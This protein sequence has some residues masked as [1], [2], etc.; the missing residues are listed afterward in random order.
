MLSVIAS[1]VFL[2]NMNA[3]ALV[4]RIRSHGPSSGIRPP[5]STVQLGLS[6]IEFLFTLETF[7]LLQ[8]FAKELKVMIS[9]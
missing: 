7:F 2:Y 1:S 4:M 5:L 8:P 6:G 9:L 3:A